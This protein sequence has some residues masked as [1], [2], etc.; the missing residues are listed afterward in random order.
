MRIILPSGTAA[1][2]VVA[3][4]ADLGLV[5]T[6]DIFGLRPLYDDMAQRLA[7]EWEVVVCAAE[8]FPGKDLGPDV[9]PRFAAAFDLRRRPPARPARGC[10]RHRV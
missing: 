2:L 5:I 9:E 7:N 4:G 3:D 10:R 1:E 8:P 6:P